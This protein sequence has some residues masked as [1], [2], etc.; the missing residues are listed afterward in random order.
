M[1]LYVA[2]VKHKCV[3]TQWYDTEYCYRVNNRKI[4]NDAYKTDI[5]MLVRNNSFMPMSLQ[6]LRV[7]SLRKLIGW[8]QMMQQFVKMR[9]HSSDRSFIILF[10][11]DFNSRCSCAFSLLFSQG[12]VHPLRTLVQSPF[13]STWTF[14]VES[15]CSLVAK[16]P[17]KRRPRSY[18]PWPK[19]PH[20]RFPIRPE[21]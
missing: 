7:H 8:I 1:R 12:L 11:A 15:E 6:A 4:R 10:C 18:C 17:G 16:V 9:V 14:H 19:L 3:G 20:S 13:S 21:R 5:T 2:T